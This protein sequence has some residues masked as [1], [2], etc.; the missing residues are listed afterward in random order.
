MF[1]MITLNTAQEALRTAY[2]QVEKALF[3]LEKELPSAAKKPNKR[4]ESALQA[5][6]A[7][8][9]ALDNV[10]EALVWTALHT[11]K[12][13]KTT[14]EMVAQLY[15][16]CEEILSYASE[17]PN[18]LDQRGIISSFHA[19]QANLHH[20]YHWLKKI[21]G[22]DLLVSQLRGA[23]Q[24]YLDN[25]K[26]IVKAHIGELAQKNGV[27]SK[28]EKTVSKAHKAASAGGLSS[29]TGLKDD[30]IRKEPYLRPELVTKVMDTTMEKSSSLMPISITVTSP[31]RPS[32]LVS[33]YG[34]EPDAPVTVP[35]LADSSIARIP[36]HSVFVPN[37][38][39][40]SALHTIAKRQLKTNQQL[41]NT[42]TK[43]SEEIEKES[44]EEL[45][46]AE[47]VMVRKGQLMLERLY[48]EQHEC[49][50]KSHATLAK[51]NISER[52]HRN[53]LKE[54]DRLERRRIRRLSRVAEGSFDEEEEEEANSRQQS[55][56]TEGEDTAQKKSKH[57][58]QHHENKNVKESV[59]EPKPSVDGPP[60]E[61]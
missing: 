23:L 61:S 53:M 44:F 57:E 4:Y 51:L 43:T 15:P 47:Q 8:V 54:K 7:V 29:M 52:C 6:M 1:A 22:V 41:P 17:F 39:I 40:L 27:R 26:A 24:I 2:G 36:E 33:S 20:D 14:W 19:L 9:C 48:K 5:S 21:T 28:A 13:P 60:G 25:R 18:F 58:E 56:D 12:L 55:F 50:S 45:A 31:S 10:T 3:N 37:D 46:D 35:P 59:P 11:F 49:K 34:D 30:E 38:G 16:F 42:P 32:S